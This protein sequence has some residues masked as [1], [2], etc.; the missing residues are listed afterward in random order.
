[1][2]LHDFSEKLNQNISSYGTHLK[3]TRER[4]HEF[5]ISDFDLQLQNLSEF[6]HLIT[7]TMKHSFRGSRRLCKGDPKW[8]NYISRVRMG[9]NARPSSPDATKLTN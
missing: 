5:T 9:S 6:S 8:E 2:Y 7:K 3:A 4:N 1:M